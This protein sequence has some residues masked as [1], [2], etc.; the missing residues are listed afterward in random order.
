MTDTA[1]IQLSLAAIWEYL[2][3]RVVGEDIGPYPQENIVIGG[4]VSK[5]KPGAPV[6]IARLDAL[7]ACKAWKAFTQGD[8]NA[9]N[10]P[11]FGSVLETLGYAIGLRSGLQLAQATQFGAWLAHRIT[12]WSEGEATEE[13][14]LYLDRI[15]RQATFRPAVQAV[16]TALRRNAEHCP[17]ADACMV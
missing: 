9:L 4:C 17:S 12:G 5:R 6:E 1:E 14:L 3:T 16:L 10:D 8:R 7:V 13:D 15:A 2:R 11:R